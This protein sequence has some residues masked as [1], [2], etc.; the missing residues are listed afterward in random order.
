MERATVGTWRK[1]VNKCI[2]EQNKTCFTYLACAGQKD[3]LNY[4]LSMLLEVIRMDEFMKEA[5]ILTL[6]H[7]LFKKQASNYFMLTIF[8]ENQDKIKDK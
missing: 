8:A 3:V 7:T 1:W 5:G 2:I 4:Y 6:F